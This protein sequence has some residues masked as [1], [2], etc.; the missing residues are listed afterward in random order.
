MLMLHTG[1]DL[2][3]LSLGR[4]MVSGFSTNLLFL[5]ST[6]FI[7]NTP[8]SATVSSIAMVMALRYCGFGLPW[9]PVV[10]R[11]DVTI[12]TLSSSTMVTMLIES[13]GSET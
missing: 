8:V 12:V 6:P 2:I 10:A 4:L 11:F 5:M 3:F 7:I 1:V 13:M 9:L